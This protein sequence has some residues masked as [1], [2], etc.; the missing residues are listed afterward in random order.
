M[1][2]TL[3]DQDNLNRFVNIA[4]DYFLAFTGKVVPRIHLR[5][6]AVATL[7]ESGRVCASLEV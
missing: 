6:G 4:Y 1:G 7:A 5:G 2:D 3:N